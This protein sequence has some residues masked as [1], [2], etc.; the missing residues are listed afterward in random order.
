ML[1]PSRLCLN[2]SS[3]HEAGPFV[4]CF[5]HAVNGEAEMESGRRHGNR[6]EVPCCTNSSSICPL[7]AAA[8]PIE[9]RCSKDG[10][11]LT[12][13]ACVALLKPPR[14][15]RIVKFVATW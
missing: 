3:A 9:P 1:L 10:G 12:N 13:A 5:T 4:P 2:N 14:D 8:P 11:S 7:V 15:A 6:L